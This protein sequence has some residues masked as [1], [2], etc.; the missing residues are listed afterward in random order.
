M[1]WKSLTKH[2]GDMRKAFNT[3][4]AN[5]DGY[6]SKSEVAFYLKSLFNTLEKKNED[7]IV[8]KCFRHLDL[9]GDG[10]ISYPEF[11]MGWKSYC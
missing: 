5:Q 10:K 6:I 8:Q 11:I 2:D 9:N 3:L 4:D 1:L 7:A